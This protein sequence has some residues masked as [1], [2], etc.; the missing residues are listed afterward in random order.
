M[1]E[2]TT[3][4]TEVETTTQQINVV[5]SDGTE[6]IEGLEEHIRQVAYQVQQWAN[7]TRDSAVKSMLDRSP[8]EDT[9]NPLRQIEQARR[10]LEKNDIVATFE[11]LT[12]ALSFQGTKWESAEAD[13]ADVWNQM[14]AERNDDALVRKLYRETFATSQVIVACWW[15]RGSFPVRGK[16]EKGNARKKVYDLWYPRL[17]T[18]LDSRRV[19]PVGMLAFGQEMLAWIATAEEMEGFLKTTEDARS[20]EIVRRFYVDRYLPTEHERI[21]LASL[22]IPTDRLIL[23]NPELVRRHTLTRSDYERYAPVR[24]RPIFQLDALRQQLMEADRVALVGAANYILLVKKGDKDNP[25]TTEEVQNVKAGFRTLAKVPVIFS[26]HRLSIEIIT[27]KQDYTL[28]A[29]KYDLIDSRIIARLVNTVA[30]PRGASS[31][32]SSQV[33]IGKTVVAALEDRR[34]MLRRFLET[35]LSREV[36]RHPANQAA[37]A[38]I[39]TTAPSFVYTPARI[40][41][42]D[43]AS[44]AQQIISLR[45]MREISRET[46]LERFGMD[47]E[48]EALRMAIEKEVYD[49]TFQSVVPFSS[50]GQGGD[51]GDGEDPNSGEGDAPVKQGAAGVQGGRPK[52]GGKTSQN[53]TKTSRT[54]KGTTP[55]GSS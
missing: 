6:Q 27:P 52:G 26:D 21:E 54:S 42:D 19:V 33:S 24:L 25:A 41:I 18:V 55:K 1:S 8:W 46:L 7:S 53:P 5:Y 43:E 16:T 39:A 11:E 10:V 23:L 15:D 3:T 20:D 51:A 17:V 35:I 37:L 13:L 50:P 48:A 47:Q 36:F 49:D 9:D 29:E 44:I 32:S 28:N 40:S 30:Q 34:H 4:G 38:S 31:S 45:T 12:E 22:G 14:S 2:P